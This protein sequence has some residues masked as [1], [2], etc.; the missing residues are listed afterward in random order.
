[1]LSASWLTNTTQHDDISMTVIDECRTWSFLSS[2]SNEWQNPFNERQNKD[3]SYRD[4]HV[5]LELYISEISQALLETFWST[6]AVKNPLSSTATT[7]SNTRCYVYTQY[8]ATKDCRTVEWLSEYNNRY[9]GQMPY[10]LLERKIIL[11]F[12]FAV[13]IEVV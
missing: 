5:A 3:H 10:D 13:T 4:T 2:S 11:F 1:M 9:D 7:K 12:A 6:T 8:V